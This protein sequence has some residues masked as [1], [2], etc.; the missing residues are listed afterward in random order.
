MNLPPAILTGIGCVTGKQQERSAGDHLHTAYSEVLRGKNCVGCSSRC[1]F[2]AQGTR[3]TGNAVVI[4]VTLAYKELRI[5]R[6]DFVTL[7]WLACL[8]EGL[9]ACFLL[10]LPFSGIKQQ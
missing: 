9:E 2:D 6:A 3:T 5:I 1:G 4:K 8:D 7:A 10:T